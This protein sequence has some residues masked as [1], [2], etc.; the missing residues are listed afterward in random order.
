MYRWWTG[1]GNGNRAVNSKLT[2]EKIYVT[3]VVVIRHGRT[4]WNR[5]E[6]FRGRAD[7]GLDDVGI[8]QAQATVERIAGWNVSALYYSPLNRTTTTANIIAGRLNITAEPLPGIID[9]DYGGWQGLS[10]EEAAKKDKDLYTLWL[11]KPHLVKFPGGESLE[12][13]RERVASSVNNLVERH[14]DDTIAVVSHKVVCQILILHFLG[15]DT[16]RFWQIGQDVSAVN[17]FEVKDNHSYA[18]LL[19]DTCHLKKLGLV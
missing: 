2:A 15:M 14:P 7:L 18:R 13:V 12:E 4:E 11:Q 3:Q 10:P 8:R 16:S 1:Y 9:I 19:N 17:L 5:V 6:R